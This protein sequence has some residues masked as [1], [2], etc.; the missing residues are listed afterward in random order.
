MATATLKF[1]PKPENKSSKSGYIP[2]YFRIILN[3]TK[4]EGKVN[5]KVKEDELK[6][7]NPT[8]MRFEVKNSMVFNSELI[9]IETNFLTFIRDY[10]EELANLNAR[11]VKERISHL[12]GLRDFEYI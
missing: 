1:L 11:Q 4:A 5:L 9:K 12:Y 7:W 6:L 10:S 3:C 2:V 8:S